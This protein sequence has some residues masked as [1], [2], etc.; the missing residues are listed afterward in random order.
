MLLVLSLSS[1]YHGIQAD[2]TCN[3][4]RVLE[5]CGGSAIHFLG[6]TAHRTWISFRW[7]LWLNRVSSALTDREDVLTA[8]REWE[9]VKKKSPYQEKKICVLSI[10]MLEMH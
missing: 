10:W 3:V 1:A 8:Y 9:K 2:G 6:Y 5:L 7:C 4:S